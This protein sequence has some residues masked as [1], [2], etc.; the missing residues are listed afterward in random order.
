MCVTLNEYQS[1]SVTTEETVSFFR[2][3]PEPRGFGFDR[4]G[5][6]TFKTAGIIAGDI[7]TA[8]YFAMVLR[9][10]KWGAVY[11]QCVP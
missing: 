2:L 5:T 4:P 8:D 10:R 11:T 9:K 6:N 3:C 7:S 1:R